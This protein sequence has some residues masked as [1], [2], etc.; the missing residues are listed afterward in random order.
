MS[1]AVRIA[2]REVKIRKD[3]SCFGCYDKHPKGSSMVVQVN[4]GDGQIYSIYLCKPC[5]LFWEKISQ[6]ED[7][8]LY[9]GDLTQYDDYE[10]FKQQV[11]KGK[12]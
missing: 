1:G 12:L 7:E 6:N 9:Q 8:D 5:D 10:S 3:R 4:T 2:K 11:L